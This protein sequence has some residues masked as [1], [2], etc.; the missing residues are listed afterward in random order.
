MNCPVTKQTPAG[1]LSYTYDGAGHV[2][3]M[4][5]S[6]ANGVNVS[7]SYDS[8]GRLGTV[9][10]HRLSGN[11]TTTYG[12]DASNVATVTYPNGVQTVLQYD[13]L[14]RV[15]GLAAASGAAEV[16]NAAGAVTDTYDYDAFGNLLNSTGSTPNVYKYRGEQYDADLG[17]YYLRARYYNPQ[18]GRFMSRDPY[19]PRLIGLGMLFSMLTRNTMSWG[20]NC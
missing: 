14:N 12:Y 19:K 7:Y 20:E 11:Q 2:E 4:Q 1:T 10:D 3:T 16:T 13:D 9:V 5:S 17:L 6:N 18:T 8:L 15:T